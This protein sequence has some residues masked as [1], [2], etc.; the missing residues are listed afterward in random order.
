VSEV[1]VGQERFDPREILLRGS[2]TWNKWRR[3]N[4]DVVIDLNPPDLREIDFSETN[5]RG[6]NLSKTDLR[7]INLSGA[8]L[9]E[10]DLSGADLSGAD[11][12]GAYLREA[13]LSGAN[14]SGVNLREA[15]L[16]RVNLFMANLSEANLGEANL[17]M[18]D[19]SGADLSG[20]DL[21][22]VILKGSRRYGTL[23]EGLDETIEI[24]ILD[25]D[26]D[27]ASVEQLDRAINRYM[28]VLG[29]ER[30]EVLDIE[31]GSL[32]K[33][34]RYAISTFLTPE[35]K[36][37]LYKESANLYKRGKA[38]VEAKLDQIGVES[39]QQMVT[40][41]ADLL[42]SIENFDNIALRLGKLICAKVTDSNGKSQVFVETISLALQNELEA[43]PKILHNPQAVAEFLQMEQEAAVPVALG[44]RGHD[45]QAG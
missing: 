39:T 43:N 45:L 9:R 23:L 7:G 25:R 5:L 12:S 11:L 4:P 19:L 13:N 16:S 10:I 34:V 17:F 21:N 15:N 29:Y 41:T 3:D 35:R 2:E 20:A 22:G 28:V 40:A 36:E 14:L 32:F 26:I 30:F 24:N 44:D 37:Q 6:I 31:R 27:L 1:E 8:D 18:A 33:K 42:K 38:N